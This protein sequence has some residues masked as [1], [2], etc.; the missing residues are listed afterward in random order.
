MAAIRFSH[1]SK[2]YP[3]GHAAV[4]DLNLEIEDGEFLVLVGPSG[5]IAVNVMAFTGRSNR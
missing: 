4:R 1:V 5:V 2:T 3:G